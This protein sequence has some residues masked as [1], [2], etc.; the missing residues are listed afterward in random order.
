MNT[1]IF[2]ENLGE[3]TEL[4]HSKIDFLQQKTV[5]LTSLPFE[6][7]TLVIILQ[8]LEKNTFEAFVQKATE[9]LNNFEIEKSGSNLKL[10]KNLTRELH[11]EFQTI[12]ILNEW[13]FENYINAGFKGVLNLLEKI[14]LLNEKITL[15]EFRLIRLIKVV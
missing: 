5:L 2:V 7:N 9:L 14:F 8:T 10:L 15:V 4:Q 1:T 6:K 13:F 12:C 11:L 3:W